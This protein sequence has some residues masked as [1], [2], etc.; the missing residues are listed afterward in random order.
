VKLVGELTVMKKS[1]MPHIGDQSSDSANLIGEGCKIIGQITGSADF[2]INGEIDGD[3][4]LSGSVTIGDKGFWKGMLKAEA[5]F[6][7]GRVEGEIIANGNLEVTDSA[8]INGN[9]RGTSIAIAE[10]AI[11]EGVIQTNGRQIARD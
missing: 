8:R 11:I 4:D 9:V 7:S 1:K 2:I 10:G 6:V 3:C 5:I